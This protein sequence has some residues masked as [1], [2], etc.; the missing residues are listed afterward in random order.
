M[1]AIGEVENMFRTQP[2]WTIEILSPEQRPTKVIGNILHCLNHGCQI[3]WLIDPEE[4]SLLIYPS[5]Q[6]P[7]FLEA[8]HDRLPV[9]ELVSDLQLTVG[10]IFGWLKL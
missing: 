10:D 7:E 9:P 4:R 2:D 8:E 6:Q 5:G 3:G 1:N